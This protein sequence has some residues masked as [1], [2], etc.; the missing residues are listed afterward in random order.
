MFGR[1]VLTSD[2]RTPLRETQRQRERFAKAR[3]AET[4]YAV[5]LRKVARQVG[6]FVNA[7]NFTEPSAVARLKALLDRYAEIITPWARTTAT[8]MLHD[9]SRRDLSAWAK[10]SRYMARSLEAEIRSAPTGV[11]M[12]SLLEENVKLITSL[13]IEAGRRVQKIAVESITTGARASE[14]AK[15]IMKSGEVTKSRA[16]LIARTETGRAASTLTMVRAESI[17][18][19]GYIWRTARDS[20]VRPSHKKMEGQVVEWDKPPTLDGLTGHAGAIPNCRCYMEVIVP[21]KFD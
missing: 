5:S 19:V 18:S 17:G 2:L 8:R 21:D 6:E 3:R 15:E 13:P 1:R 4:Q 20:D 9:V 12:R 16:N 14:L 7:F 10:Q 11:A